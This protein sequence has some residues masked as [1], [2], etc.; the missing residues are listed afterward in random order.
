M[1]L[2]IC[3]PAFVV[4][5]LA[6]ECLGQSEFRYAVFDIPTLGGR[7]SY[8]WAIN[9]W[10]VVGAAGSIPNNGGFHATRYEN[11]EALDLGTLG[12]RNSEPK[13][14]NNMD[15][16]VGR[17]HGPGG[18]GFDFRPFLWRE[19]QMEDL[20]TLGGDFGEAYA[21]NEL[22]HI[23]GFTETIPGQRGGWQAFL[24]RD[25]VMGRLPELDG[26]SIAWGLNNTGLV[27][28]QSW[29]AEFGEP[30]AVL[31]ENGQVR[32]LGTLRYDGRGRSVAIDLCAVID[33]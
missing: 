5:L 21:I 23:V 27:A 2:T 12:G 17:A 30:R 6:S 4:A 10:G 1:K 7:H 19:G 15:W 29:S 20:G 32:D 24:W 28:G 3:R 31:W 9:D 8:A 33:N 16:I 25:G 13:G 14:I 22:G 26:S 18:S 11:G